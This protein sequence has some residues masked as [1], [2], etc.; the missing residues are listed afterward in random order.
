MPDLEID[1]DRG[2]G[3]NRFVTTLIPALSRSLAEQF[4]VFRVMHHGTHEKQLS[5][6]FAW[7]LTPDA[8]HH[9]GD[10]FQRIMLNR[11]NEGLTEELR[12]PA[13]GYRVTQEVDTRGGHEISAGDVG[14]DI[15][16]IV[17]SRHDAAVVIENY[18][19]S[20]GHGHDYHRYLAHGATSGRAAAVV[21]LCHRRESQLQRD[22]WENAVVVT[23]A[24]ILGDLQDHIARDSSWRTRNPDQLFFIEQMIQHFVEGPAAVNVDD[25]ISFIQTMCET[26]ESARYGYRP[27]DRAAQE[28]AD[29]VAEHA[30]RQF[31]DGRRTLARVKAGLR[32]FGRTTLTEQVNDVVASGR[33]EGILTNFA[34]KW[35]WCIEL[36]RADEQPSIFLEFGP[37]AAVENTR[38]PHPLTD[39]DYSRVFVTIHAAGGQ[40]LERIMQ[41]DVTLSEVLDGLSADDERLRDAVLTVATDS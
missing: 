3:M 39:P 27:Q 24:E 21:L 11:V 37:T 15:A 1:L 13:A 36:Q 8:T 14:M 9:M 6:V 7:L 19:T 22:G 29:L 33:V 34:G 5:N 28:F 32:S 16:D 40:N 10:V 35:E 2:T 31:Q 12:L 23:Y 18:G 41:T 38:V 17:L 26:G 4:N 30:R 20:D 25:Q